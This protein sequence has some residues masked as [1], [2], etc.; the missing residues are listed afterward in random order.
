LNL[1]LTI[2]FFTF[3]A[4][5][6][7]MDKLTGRKK[8]LETLKSLLNSNK[9]EFIAVYG[10]RRVGKTFLIRSAFNQQ[11]TFQ[12]TAL[13]NA[14]LSQQ[15]TN[16]YVALQKVYPAI[17]HSASTD[18][19]SA[20]QQLIAYTEGKKEDRKIIFFD[21]LPWFDTQ[22]SG[23][24]QAL[25]HFWNSWA[26]ARN[27][28]I[29]IVCGSAASWMINK[30]I[31]N[32]G[33]LYNRVTKRIKLAPFS[34]HECE[35]FLQSKNTVLDR[36][37]IIQLYMAFGGIPFYWDEVM[38]GKS[39]AQNINEI[40][41]SEN[42]LLRNEFPNLFRS[43][44]NNY[45]KHEAVINA[46]TQKAKGL[47]REE[48]LNLTGLPNAGSTTKVLQELEESGFI[49]K[50]TPFGKKSRN[51]LYQLNDFYSLFYQRFI[52][53]SLS[54]EQDNWLTTIDSPKYRAWSGYA[55][56]QVCLY[57][58]PQIKQALGISGVQTSV[59]AWRSKSKTDG[60]QIDLVI[61]R[62]DQVIN[63]CEMKYSINPFAIDKKYAEELRD[64]AGIFKS[65]TNTRKSVFLTMITTFGLKSN[66][67]STGLIQNDLKMDIL[68]ADI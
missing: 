16:F 61:D 63:L 53:N 62:R 9:S 4:K 52:K 44:F 7:I 31:N 37:Q 17:E 55:F 42:G 19:F 54:A 25:E 1:A 26:S 29:L 20:F 40:C 65:E 24:I 50:Y 18:W 45:H 15:L 28:I 58:L 43:L 49:R 38:P 33:G 68:F 2:Y 34:L 11:F 64:K 47:T 3:T 13:A 30:L 5:F 27:D 12:V 51:S 56:E 60:A 57:H 48:I 10:R 36:Y 41:F 6:S 46:L 35:L 59:S 23:F 14:T 8:E 21:E 22:A 67:Y 32:K 39:A 66:N